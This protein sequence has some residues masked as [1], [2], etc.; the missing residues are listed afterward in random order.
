M[1]NVSRLNLSLLNENLALMR[2]RLAHN[3][4]VL[5]ELPPGGARQRRAYAVLTDALFAAGLARALEASESSVK[6]FL[7]MAAHAAMPMFAGYGKLLT[8]I[9]QLPSGAEEQFGDTSMT[10]PWTYV[11]T[12]Y[13][14]LVA[15][16]PE[17]LSFLSSLDAQNF[18]TSQGT[19]APILIEYSLLLQC[20]I[21]QECFESTKTMTQAFLDTW[22]D[23]SSSEDTYWL[24]QVR[25]INELLNNDIAGF[26]TA[27][28]TV[29]ETVDRYYVDSQQWD[30]PERF[31]ALPVLALSALENQLTRP[32]GA[33]QA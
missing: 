20:V 32:T 29:K 5:R 3:Q 6:A 17:V 21:S 11:Q 22:G 7:A 1:K 19:T 13:A 23:C 25:A 12:V 16:I 9:T 18:Q 10:N 8:S 27:L 30:N 28:I 14:A 4:D 26:H 31:L 33:P 15:D 24:V 2:E